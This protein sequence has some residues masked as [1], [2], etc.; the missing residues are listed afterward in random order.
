MSASNLDLCLSCR[1]SELRG[2]ASRNHAPVVADAVEDQAGKVSEAFRLVLPAGTFTD[3]DA[4]DTLTLSAADLPGWLTFDAATQ[5][6]SGT[7]MQAGAYTVTVVARDAAGET[8]SDS[9]VI[10]VAP[11]EP[12]TPGPI[13]IEA[14][15]FTHR[16]GYS[17]EKLSTASDGQVIK[18]G[19][20]QSGTTST[21]LASF[22]VEAGTYAVTIAYIDEN[23]GK[24]SAALYVDGVKVGDWLF[25]AATPG[26]GTQVENLRTFTFN[27]VAIGANS[28]IEMRVTANSSEL[29]RIDY[30]DIW[31]T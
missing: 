21:E 6:F 11:A 4:G 1:R 17:V 13:R 31:A 2:G 29:A 5:T 12:E 8:V 23:D 3:V 15:D 14:E 26:A 7:P 16:S 19:A 28:V 27:D 22:G 24:S 18:L 25:D 20:R 30:V 9:F 10:E